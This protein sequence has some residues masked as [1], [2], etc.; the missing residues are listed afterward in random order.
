VRAAEAAARAD[1]VVLAIPLRRLHGLDPEPFRGRIVIDATNHSPLWGDPPFPGLADA[2][3]T[4]ELVQRHLAGA[5]VVKTLNHL[6]IDELEEDAA[7]PGT[8]HRRALAVAGDDGAAVLAAM[9]VVDRLGFDA[10]DAGPLAAGVALEP[11]SHVFNGLYTREELAALFGAP[12]R[13]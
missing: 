2:P 1:V 3:S 11:R 4:S 8:P 7:P 6:G 13:R 10:V 9:A 12:G 5:C